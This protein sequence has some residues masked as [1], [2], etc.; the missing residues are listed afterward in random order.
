MVEV[1]VNK[2]TIPP[3]KDATDNS[4]QSLNELREE[5]ANGFFQMAGLGCII[6]SQF[7]DAGAINM[8]GPAISHVAAKMAQTNE[9]MAKGLDSLLTVG[10]YTEI[11]GVTLPLVLQLLVNHKVM[12]AE[13]V[14]GANVVRPE[15]LESQV[16]TQLAMQAME[17]MKAQQHAEQEMAKMREEMM[18]AQNGANPSE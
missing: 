17:A 13:M 2:S 12:P 10:P 9:L 18:A 8:H 1:K 3:K 7:S 15:V 16:K 14:A 6:F 11:I 4:P 5:A